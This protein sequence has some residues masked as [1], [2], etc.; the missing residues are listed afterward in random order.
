MISQ[1]GRIH[2][3]CI[4]NTKSGIYRCSGVFLSSKWIKTGSFAYHIICNGQRE[5][6]MNFPDYS[7]LTGPIIPIS[8][9]IRDWC[10]SM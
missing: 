10:R 4:L 7:N 2:F 8:F 3:M 1:G 9:I 6:F 5:N